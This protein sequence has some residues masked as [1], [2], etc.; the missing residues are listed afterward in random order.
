[1]ATTLIVEDG[2][3][4][5]NANAFVSL[6]TCDTYHTLRGNATWT[7]TD[8]LK[9]AAIIQAT[10]YLDRLRWKGF[11]TGMSNPLAWPRYGNDVSG[12][13]G[14]VSP[15]SPLMGVVDED[16]Y[17]VGA[18]TVPKKVQ[19]ATCEM[20]LRFLTG[21]VPEPDLDR[22]GKIKSQTIDVISITYESGASPVPVYTVLKNL[23]RGLLQSSATV[24]LQLGM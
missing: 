16:G 10:F 21:A 2:T 23:L 14:M 1:M 6:A 22:G 8:A 3:V 12:W 18:A 24:E 20:A 9:E 13:N 7:G 15:A 19:D 17:D 4:V 5:A 11:K